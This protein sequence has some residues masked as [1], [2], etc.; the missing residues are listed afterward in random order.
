M[1]CDM[2]QGDK[3]KSSAVVELS[4]RKDD[5]LMNVF[6]DD[7]NL[8]NKLR[9]VVKQFEANPANR[10]NYDKVMQDHRHVSINAFKRDFNGKRI[11]AI[12]NLVKSCLR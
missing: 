5:F 3:V 6:P 11:R 10:N 4:R 12:F 8:I 2:H 1:P 9:N 7:V